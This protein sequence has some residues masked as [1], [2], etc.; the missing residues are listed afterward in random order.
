MIKTLQPHQLYFPCKDDFLT[1]IGQKITHNNHALIGQKRAEE[2]LSMGLTMKADGFNVFVSGE[3][4]TGKLAAV[5]MFLEEM[6]GSEPVPDD[7]CYVHHFSDPYQP[8]K[9]NLPPG[10][11]TEFKKDMKKL[12]HEAL[13]SMI[14][15]FESEEYAS[16]KEEISHKYDDQFSALTEKINTEAEKESLMLKQTPWE[17]FTVPVKEGKPITDKDFDDLPETEKTA[18]RAKE[19]H[20]AE[21]MNNVLKQKRKMEKQVISDLSKLESEVAAFAISELVKEMESKYQRFPDVVDY[22]HIVRDDILTNLGEFLLSHKGK[23]SPYRE[24]EF[25]RR[26]EVN[27]LVDNAK[28]AGAPVVLE[29][30][31]TYNN[32]I[33]RVEK[34]S[35]MGSLVTDFTMIRKGSLHLA[36]GGYLILRAKELFQ[37]MFSWEA[38]KRAIRNKEIAIEDPSDQLGFLTT[39]SL[40]PEPIPLH[41]KIILVGSP[42]YYHLLYALDSDFKNLFKVKVDF[43]IEMERNEENAMGYVTYF[44]S[45][46]EKEN[47]GTPDADAF[48]KLIEIGSRMSEDQGKLSTRFDQIA[49]LLREAAHYAK[50]EGKNNVSRIHLQKASEKKLYRSNLVQQKIIEMI[51]KNEIL[52]NTSGKKTGQINALS[53]IDMGDIL[54]G[55][56]NRITCSLNLGKAG[57]VA[58]EREAEMSGPIHTKGVLILTG[59]LAER[60]FQDKPVSL[61]ARLVFEQSYAEIEGDSASSTELYALLSSISQL[62]LKQ[63]IAV[64]GSVN[65][66]GEIQSVGGINE[67]IEGYFELCKLIGLNG[68]QGVII[69]ASNVHHLMLKQEIIDA[70]EAKQ[71]TVWSVDFIDDGIEIL[72]GI[73]A[74]NT[75]QEG[76]VNYLVNKALQSFSLKMKDFEDPG[77]NGSEKTGFQKEWISDVVMK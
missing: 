6:K 55:K 46:C 14:Q 52:I 75:D 13:Q 16:K 66:K 71:F 54:F 62:P 23:Q 17:I 20:F 51:S 34:E 25:L 65:Q 3:D 38:I 42:L 43:N 68:E 44:K 70:V 63:G 27:V 2:A 58:I 9:L 30:N 7:W 18:I 45:L 11:A 19:A 59:Y 12:I 32:L 5:R 64:T 73:P 4:R 47:L 41:L 31:P 1:L 8:K 15:V 72:T 60:Y 21:E 53:V 33:G 22:L 74:G 67:K 40:K 50:E 61:S 10:R 35:V 24:N 69:P 56:P 26:Y 76:T 36:N 39:K 57:V 29:I 48:K 49:D 28:Q 37:N 77:V